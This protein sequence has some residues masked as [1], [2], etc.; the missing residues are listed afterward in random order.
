MVE[1]NTT[2]KHINYVIL[3]MTLVLLHG[4]E[5]YDVLNYLLCHGVFQYSFGLPNSL[6][7]PL[8]TPVHT[9]IK[10]ERKER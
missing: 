4:T 9:E 6:M 5:V 10:E 3:L 8:L 1:G 7:I 2:L